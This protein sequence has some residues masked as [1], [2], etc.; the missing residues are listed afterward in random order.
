MFAGTAE[1]PHIPADTY[2]CLVSGTQQA[3]KGRDAGVDRS[4]T[5]QLLLCIIRL[6]QHGSDLLITVN[7][8]SYISPSSSAAQHA[9]AQGQQA[10]AEGQAAAVM[11]GVLRSLRV[12]DWGLFGG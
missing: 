4:N 3:C 5:V 9:D 11:Q 12:Q 7:A 8:P 1:V 10:G 2:M 6:P